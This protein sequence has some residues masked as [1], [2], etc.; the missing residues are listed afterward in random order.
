MIYRQAAGTPADFSWE[1][2]DWATVWMWAAVWGEELVFAETADELVGAMTPGQWRVEAS[3][4]PEVVAAELRA[5]ASRTVASVAQSH[6]AI[7]EAE[8]YGW[9]VTAADPSHVEAIMQSREIVY[10]QPTW[11]GPMPLVLPACDYQPWAPRLRPTGD[12]TWIDFDAESLLLA[13]D[14]FHLIALLRRTLI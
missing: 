6:I 9:D 1:A 4:R 14:R 8:R 13:M 11:D 5:A 12:I 2:G 10:D 3:M 7:I